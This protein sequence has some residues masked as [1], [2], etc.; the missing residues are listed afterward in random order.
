MFPFYAISKCLFDI[1]LHLF[2]QPSLI[3][4]FVVTVHN[5]ATNISQRMGKHGYSLFIPVRSWPT[6]VFEIL[7]YHV[8]VTVGSTVST[9][10]KG[11]YNI[12]KRCESNSTNHS[13][14]SA[15]CNVILIQ[16]AQMISLDPRVNVL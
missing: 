8:L 1:D 14:I 11:K 3:L 4:L 10:L 16:I 6:C 2:C 5:T 7:R 12:L 13:H 9:Q 15:K